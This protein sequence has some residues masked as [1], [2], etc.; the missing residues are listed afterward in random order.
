MTPA[1]QVEPWSEQ[2]RLIQEKST[3]GLYLTGHPISQFEQDL[4]HFIT[5]RLG[6]LTEKYD[7]SGNPEGVYGRRQEVKVVVAGLV[8]E[9]RAKQNQN[10]KRMAFATLDDRTG[11][12]EVAVFAEAFDQYREYLVKDTLLV[13]EGNLSWDDFAN[14]LRL[15]ADKLMSID[16]ARVAFA[17]RLTL[18][19]PATAANGQA[20][21]LVESLQTAMTPFR[22]GPCPVFIEYRA[23]D[24]ES[25][26]QLGEEWRLRP[27]Q[28]LLSQLES[29]LGTGAVQVHY[30]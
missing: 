28:T 5:D 14:Q 25:L 1:L 9:L 8:V 30:A 17:R 13:A 12:M 20:A 11:R 19:W 27:E 22:G 23:N 21:G 4:A 26:I 15:S 6:P 16:Q 3:L 10:G 18:R 29:R 7:R 24:A 2:E